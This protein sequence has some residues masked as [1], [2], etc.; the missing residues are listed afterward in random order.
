[1]N[2]TRIYESFIADRRGR[3]Q[4]SGLSYY[5]RITREKRARHRGA[6]VPYR[7]HHHIVARFEGGD[8]SAGNIVTLTYREHVFA[9]L[10]LAKAFG[11]K[12][13]AALWGVAGMSDVPHMERKISNAMRNSKL[14]QKAR[15][16]AASFTAGAKNAQADT[17]VYEWHNVR[18]GECIEATRHDMPFSSRQAGAYLNQ[19]PNKKWNVKFAAGAW[20]VL[21]VL[22]ASHEDA[23]R[24]YE[25]RNQ[26]NS[27]R[28]R[29]KRTGAENHNTRKVRC[30]ETRVV[31]ESQRFAASATGAQQSKISECC[32]GTRKTAGGYHWEYVS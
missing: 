22:Y 30:I 32:K 28:Q 3:D 11:G 15:E 21:G 10:C 27:A 9:H 20:Y 2:Y 23:R 13:Y 19:S 31:Y 12:H 18:T 8:N 5:G 6:D 29:G 7:E 17:A 4:L 25:E 16:S 26:R 24:E 1:M 14:L